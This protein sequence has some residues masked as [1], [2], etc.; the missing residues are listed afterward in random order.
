MLAAA[1]RKTYIKNKIAQT[2][3]LGE[4]FHLQK[5]PLTL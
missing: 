1:Y 5:A 3:N 4:L 2:N